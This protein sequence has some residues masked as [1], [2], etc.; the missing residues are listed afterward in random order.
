MDLGVDFTWGRLQ[1]LVG[2]VKVGSQHI[3]R[4]AEVFRDTSKFI[5]KTG[6]FAQDLPLPL[7]AEKNSINPG[8]QH[9][10][11]YVIVLKKASRSL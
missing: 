3:F 10:L 4:K 7:A 6:A 5:R 9:S 11:M 8:Q 2:S 1:K